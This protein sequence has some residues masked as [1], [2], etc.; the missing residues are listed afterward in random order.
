MCCWQGIGIDTQLRLNVLKSWQT[1][2]NQDPGF[3]LQP[4]RCQQYAPRSSLGPYT[5]RPLVVFLSGVSRM[6]QLVSQ[7][8]IVSR[9]SSGK[10]EPASTIHPTA[11]ESGGGEKSRAPRADHDP[12]PPR[13]SLTG[14]VGGGNLMSSGP[15]QPYLMMILPVEN[16]PMMNMPSVQK[17]ISSLSSRSIFLPMP[18]HETLQCCAMVLDP[19][20]RLC[21]QKLP[22]QTQESSER[23]RMPALTTCLTWLNLASAARNSDRISAAR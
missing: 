3:Y 9:N 5:L 8:R 21:K 10:S 22:C 2:M 13:M 18:I 12:A 16:Q 4:L 6:T 11:C 20:S 14:S 19:Q 23:T 7:D 15:D 1:C 17:S